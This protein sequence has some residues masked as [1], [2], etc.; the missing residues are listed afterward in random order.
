MEPKTKKSKA[1]VPIIAPL[2]KRLNLHLGLM[3]NPK[4]GLM[5]RSSEGKPINFDAMVRDV[6][7]PALRRCSVCLRS[8][9]DHQSASHEFALDESLPQWHGWHAFRRRLA[10]NLRRLGV[11]DEVI[12]RVLRHSNVAVTQK[13]YIKTLD[14]D[15]VDAMRLLERSV[16][17]A[18]NMH[19]FEQK[20]SRVM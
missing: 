8:E 1:P 19:L 13:H 11:K 7:K 17:N 20:D 12:Q 18:P 4:S 16:E 5:F 14:E 2:A 9:T 15:V 3:G 10:T 6:I